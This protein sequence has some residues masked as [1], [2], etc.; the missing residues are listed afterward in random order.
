MVFLG[1]CG[2]D[3]FY[4][5][6]TIPGMGH[7]A[8]GPGAWK[9]GQG[10]MNGTFTNTLNQTDHNVLLSLVEWVEGGFVP[11]I[12][13]GVDNEGKER[14]HCLWPR[15]KSVWDGTDWDCVSA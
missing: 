14:K 4:R 7:C 13:I 3:D 15:E 8:G 10:S 9:I 5:L 2:L 6:F 11:E 1:T 12:V